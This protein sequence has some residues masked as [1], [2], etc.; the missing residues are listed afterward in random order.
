MP[1]W[2]SCLWEAGVLPSGGS[3]L[4]RMHPQ[5]M[6]GKTPTGYIQRPTGS[7]PSQVLGQEGPRK[8]APRGILNIEFGAGG[9]EEKNLCCGTAV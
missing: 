6:P 2:Y 1:C 7:Y 9:G 8:K 4:R 5:N 3:V